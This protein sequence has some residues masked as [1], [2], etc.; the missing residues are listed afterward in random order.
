MTNLLDQLRAGVSTDSAGETRRLGAG[1]AELLPADTVLALHG[2]L[3]AGKTTLV[4]GLASGLGIDGPVTSP[5]FTLVRLYPANTGSKSGRMLAHLDAY[6]LVSTAQAEAL[7]LHEFLVSPWCL[8]VEWPENVSSW[9][10]GNAWHLDLGIDAAG[11]HT[12]RLR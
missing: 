2:D 9:L 6:R 5:T 8:A 1:L 4:Q 12:L 3:G 10:P 11:R 7:L